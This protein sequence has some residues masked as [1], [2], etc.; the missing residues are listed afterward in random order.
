MEYGGC[1]KRYTA[2]LM[3]CASLGDPGV[4][5]RAVEMAVLASV[6]AL[7]HGIRPGRIFHDVA[8]EA[9]AAHRKIDDL[10]YFSGAYGYT[11]GVGYPPTWA[12]TIGFISDGAEDI[13]SAGN[14]LSFADSDA[15]SRELRCQSE[16]NRARYPR[17]VANPWGVTPENCKL[18]TS[19]FRPEIAERAGRH[20]N[21]SIL[22]FRSTGHWTSYPGAIFRY[23]K[24][25]F[26]IIDPLFQLVKLTVKVHPKPDICAGSASVKP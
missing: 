26:R 21:H 13:F 14:G 12:D 22:W 10:A 3:R 15:R 2:P 1:Y 25:P 8:M 24:S 4:E 19:N 23:W 20:L 9:K 17:R 6:Q 7:L 16:R 5:V 11:V 18:S